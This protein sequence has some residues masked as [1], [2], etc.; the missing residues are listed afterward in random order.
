M[1]GGIISTFD[2][3]LQK[4]QSEI[5]ECIKTAELLSLKGDTKGEKE[6]M[7]SELL[8]VHQR[9]QCRMNEYQ[10]LIKM[11]IEFY[12]NITQVFLLFYP[13]GIR[14]RYMFIFCFVF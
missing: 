13:Y 3:I 14:R 11:S 4:A 1:Y 7:V 8:Q 10:I 5:V 9:F 2:V 12:R 6:H